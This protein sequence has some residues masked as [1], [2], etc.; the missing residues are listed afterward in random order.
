VPARE[1]IALPSLRPIPRR[2]SCLLCN[3]AHVPGACES[4]LTTTLSPRPPLSP[5]PPRYAASAR[6]PGLLR[7]TLVREFRSHSFFLCLP[8]QLPY[9]GP[10]ASNVYE[11]PSRG[12]SPTPLFSP[13]TPRFA[14]SL[15]GTNGEQLYLRT[16]NKNVPGS[17][18]QTYEECDKV[19]EL[20]KTV[21]SSGKP[22]RRSDGV[23]VARSAPTPYHSAHPHLSPTKCAIIRYSRSSSPGAYFPPNLKHSTHLCKVSHPA[24]I[25]VFCPQVRISH[26]TSHR[27]VP[28]HPSSISKR[29]IPR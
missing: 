17:G 14:A 29:A 7:F 10:A 25:N 2:P 20:S 28:P 23:R 16:R 15:F 11:T 27:S 19:F 21:P 26:S 9:S 18:H 6:H 13:R 5:L 8:S 4:S 1:T 24:L 12:C 22:T 3:P